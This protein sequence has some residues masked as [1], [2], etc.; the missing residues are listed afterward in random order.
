MSSNNNLLSEDYSNQEKF[1]TA[2]G[3]M[4]GFFLDS[5]TL[6]LTS[7]VLIA[8]E[9]TFNATLPE[10][11]F[12]ISITLYA[13]IIGGI[14]FGYL[15]DIFGRRIT[16]L[17]TILIFG[18]FTFLTGFATSL[19]SVY[20]LRFLAGIGIGGEWGLGASLLTEAWGTKNRGASS[21]VLQSMA[22]LGAIGGAMTAAYTVSAFGFNMG[23]RYAFMIAGL[24]SLV[25]LS[26]RFFMP[27]SKKWRK[28]KEL[29]DKGQL[30]PNYDKNIPIRDIFSA[31]TIRWVIFGSLLVGGSFFLIQ[32]SLFAPTY[33]EQVV[34]I[35]ILEFTNIIILGYVLAIISAI[36]L[37]FLSDRIGRKMSNYAY[38]FMTVIL[39]LVF[40]YFLFT[41]HIMYSGSLN[42]AQIYLYLAMIFA[43]GFAGTIPVWLGELFSTKERAT[44]ANFDY[45]IGRAIGAAASFVV[46]F[47]VLPLGG[48][49]RAMGVGLIIGGL[50]YL[51]AVIFLKE[52]KGTEVK[53]ID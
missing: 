16:M 29:K 41:E 2:L 22:P 52:T 37:G 51:I 31:K 25:M 27:E 24:V 5:Y 49:G 3:V 39:A 53:A 50:L 35:P 6:L 4:P 43:T 34:R 38:A 14:I 12:A 28:Y 47:L 21:G 17:V 30:P 15:G 32:A 9:R 19:Y 40:T 1:R 11:A 33:F 20:I 8:L 48:L 10:V 46:P 23:W 18:I 44:G 13:S 26:L 45:S 36:F 7:F 42:L